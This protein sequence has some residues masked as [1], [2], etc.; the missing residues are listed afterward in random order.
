ME[1]TELLKVI[2]KNLANVQKDIRVQMLRLLESGQWN[3]TV[4]NG[5]VRIQPLD[6]P[7]VNMLTDKYME[8]FSIK[9]LIE[10]QPFS[11]EVGEVY[12]EIDESGTRL[13]SMAPWIESRNLNIDKETL[14][15][16]KSFIKQ[17]LKLELHQLI[18]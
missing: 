11:E 5:W 13:V 15:L 17:R 8:R 12:I 2:R 1:T 18:I 10:K 6:N 7:D 3:I 9:M 14:S 4:E 16:I